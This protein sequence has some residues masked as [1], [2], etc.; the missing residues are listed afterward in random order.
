MNTLCMPLIQGIFNIAWSSSNLAKSADAGRRSLLPRLPL[1]G[2]A[3]RV[4]KYMGQSLEK[5]NPR[6]MRDGREGIILHDE[7]DS[8]GHLELVS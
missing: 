4:A 7:P 5:H 1:P 8:I 2:I 3:A 6:E